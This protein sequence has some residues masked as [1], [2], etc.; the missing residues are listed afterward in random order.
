MNKIKLDIPPVVVFE[1]ENWNVG[2]VDWIEQRVSIWRQVVTDKGNN[3]EHWDIE[4]KTVSSNDLYKADTDCWTT[5][6]R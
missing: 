6:Y 3:V 1:G 2:N 5:V 4:G